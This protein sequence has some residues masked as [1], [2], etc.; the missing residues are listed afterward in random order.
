MERFVM[1][2]LFRIERVFPF[3]FTWGW[4]LMSCF[5]ADSATAADH[6]LIVVGAAGAP[7]YGEQFLNWA[8]H[9]VDLAT[10]SGATITQIG[11]G[12]IAGEAK[13]ESSDLSR[14]QEALR[15][16][17]DERTEKDSGLVWLILIGHGTYQANVAKFNLRGPDISAEQLASALLP[18]RSETVIVNVSSSSGPFVNSLSGKDRTVVTST[19]SGEEQNFARFGQFLPKALGDST[20]DLDHDEEVSLLEAVVMAANETVRFYSSE[21]RICT[22]HS[23]LDDNG[24]RL[25]TPTEML[26]MSLRGQKPELAKA[27]SDAMKVVLDG[28]KAARTILLRSGSAAPLTEEEAV[29]RVRL[30]SDVTILKQR[31]DMLTEADYF[32]QLE[33]PLLELAK[34]Y[35]IAEKR[36]E[37]EASSP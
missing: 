9:W 37:K 6:V 30:E 27:S 20:A 21:N 10:K 23:M 32:E 8:E 3:R 13:P 34:L 5:F 17:A 14:L 24:D 29:Q 15:L 22:E 19:R 36:A 2:N 28:E 18:L 33:K 4:L 31:K 12:R 35:R 25:G 7:E 11:P 26:A 1:S 16:L